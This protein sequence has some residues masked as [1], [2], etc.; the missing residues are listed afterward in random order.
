MRYIRHSRV[1]FLPNFDVFGDLLQNRPTAAWN[2]LVLHNEETTFCYWLH[3][4]KVC[5]CPLTHY[6]EES[7]RI[8]VLFSFLWMNQWAISVITDCILFL[9][10]LADFWDPLNDLPMSFPLFLFFII[11]YLLFRGS[12][13]WNYLNFSKHG[14]SQNWH[15]NLIMSLKEGKEMQRFMNLLPKLELKLKQKSATHFMTWI[16]KWQS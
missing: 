14:R 10:I 7:V 5:F 12:L 2:L 11:G 16:S 4:L 13:N 9:I 8:F 1:F 6:K 15:L 3:H